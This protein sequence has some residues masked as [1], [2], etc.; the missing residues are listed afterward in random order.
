[1][2]KQPIFSPNKVQCYFQVMKT[3]WLCHLLIHVLFKS[4]VKHRSSKYGWHIY[5]RCFHD[6]CRKQGKFKQLDVVCFD[7]ESCVLV[8]KNLNVN[9]VFCLAPKVTGQPNY[10]VFCFALLK[11]FLTAFFALYL[12]IIHWLIFC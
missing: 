9:N 2:S 6:K 10:S 7:H 3:Q 5:S 1:M 12:V 11:T 4:M 8:N